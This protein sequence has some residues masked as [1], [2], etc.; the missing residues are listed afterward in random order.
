MPFT[1][2]NFFFKIKLILRIH[3]ATL[4]S[5][6]RTVTLSHIKVPSTLPIILLQTLAE[7]VK[8]WSRQQP[9]TSPL[10]NN[11]LQGPQIKS[12]YLSV[13]SEV[14]FLQTYSVTPW[15]DKSLTF[16]AKNFYT[17]NCPYLKNNFLSVRSKTACKLPLWEKI[18]KKICFFHFTHHLIFST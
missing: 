8:E 5:A 17:L 16:C 12:L 2:Y 7:R 18:E 1:D 9:N 6:N 10:C 11:L 4:S 3:V 15:T 14:F 13:F